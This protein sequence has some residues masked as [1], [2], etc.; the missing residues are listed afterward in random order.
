MVK[1]VV[2]RIMIRVVS[3]LRIHVSAGLY[4]YNLHLHGIEEY[5]NYSEDVSVCTGV[6]LYLKS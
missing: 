6:Y 4:E 5:A 1:I 3:Q 2:L